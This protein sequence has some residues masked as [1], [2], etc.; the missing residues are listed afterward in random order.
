MF[1]QCSHILCWHFGPKEGKRR[2]WN[3]LKLDLLT[4]LDM[5]FR[6]DVLACQPVEKLPVTASGP[7]FGFKIAYLGPLKLDLEPLEPVYATIN[8]PGSSFSTGWQAKKNLLV[9]RHTLVAR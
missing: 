3:A 5:D 4:I 1:I 7:R 8:V 6:E 9:L 2:V